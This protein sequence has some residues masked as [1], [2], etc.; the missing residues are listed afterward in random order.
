M[1]EFQI[2]VIKNIYIISLRKNMAEEN[3][4]QEFR[5]KNIDEIINYFIA[6]IKQNEHLLI[7]ATAVTGCVSIS[8]SAFLAGILIGITISAVGL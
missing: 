1:K 5:L 6:E 7:L 2:Y 8:A 3:I 4:R